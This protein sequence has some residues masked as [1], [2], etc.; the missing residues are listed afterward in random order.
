MTRKHEMIR[1]RYMTLTVLQLD[2]NDVWCNAMMSP[3]LGNFTL[4]C[5]LF[6]HQTPILCNLILHHA[7]VDDYECTMFVAA[8]TD[9]RALMEL[10]LSHNEI[11]TAELLNSVKP[12][13][14]TGAEALA[15]FL[16]SSNCYIHTLQLQ[17]NKIRLDGAKSLAEA[18]LINN[19][20]THL[21]LSYNALG[22]AAG[23][24]V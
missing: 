11:G 10:D 16:C 1:G 18:L 21:N 8:I 5:A 13:T 24:I 9:N 14:T 20:L 3:S 15:D 4:L 23:E 22:S 6:L 2:V 17:W 19:T 12:D 7:D